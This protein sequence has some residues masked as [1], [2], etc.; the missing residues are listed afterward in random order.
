MACNQSSTTLFF[1]FFLVLSLT[2][3]VISHKFRYFLI[4]HIVIVLFR[5]WF[6]I[7]LLYRDFFRRLVTTLD[8]CERFRQVKRIRLIDIRL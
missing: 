2:K 7:S 5:P 3:M 1:F 4:F 8:L 6:V